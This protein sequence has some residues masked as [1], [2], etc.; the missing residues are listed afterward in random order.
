MVDISAYKR[1]KVSIDGTLLFADSARAYGLQ[2]RDVVVDGN[3]HRVNDNTSQKR[4]ND[5]GW[6]V[7][8]ESSGVWFGAYGSWYRD[9][10]NFCSHSQ[11]EL[12]P[13]Q[14]TEIKKS[15]D[16]AKIKADRL[17]EEAA[18]KAEATVENSEPVNSDHPYLLKK[19][20]HP[21]GTL[22][23]GDNILIPI[24]DIKNNIIS[25]QT[26]SP[27][28]EK[29]FL[30]KGQKKGGFH[31][32]GN[33]SPVL[34]LC[35]GF[36]TGAT[37]HEVT[38]ACVFVAFDRTNL[39]PVAAAIR[40]VYSNPIV[41]C[42]DNDQWTDGN[43][44]LTD[45]RIVSSSIVNSMVVYPSFKN[46][47]SKPTDFNDLNNLEGK[48]AVQLQLN[49][50][51]GKSLKLLYAD[52]IF[53]VTDTSDFVEDLLRDNEFS[54]IYGESNCGKT[55]FMMDLAIHV[56]LGIPWRG[57]EVEQGGVIYAALEGGHGTKNRIVAFREHYQIKNSIPLAV[58]PSNLNF[59]DTDGDI[60]ALAV[61]IAEAQ[62]RLGSVRLIVIDTLARAISGGDENS[63]MDMGKL[64]INAD[65]LRSVTG[66]HIA[67]I[68]HSGKDALKGARGHSSLRAAV[69][70]EIEISRLD[71]KSPSTI[72]IVKQREMEMIEEMS[73]ELKPV[74]LGTNSRGKQV[75]SCVVVPSE[76]ATKKRPEK[77]S[78]MQEFVYEA[79]VDCVMDYG[80]MRSVIKD[81]PQVK[82]VSYDDFKESLENRGYRDL[83]ATENK[84]TEQQVKS[85]TQTIRVNLKKR[86]KV[87]F[88]KNYIWLTNGE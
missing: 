54:V 88:N 34:Y 57:K 41:I 3:I 31:Q 51:P 52:D 10:V 22:K 29:R 82:C 43:P 21:H 84:T 28:G 73:F 63:S 27:N 30:S 18:Q 79:L 74:V 70:T 23:S 38:G 50:R 4:N 86:G 46:T 55:F 39:A 12:T 64:I 44:G 67:F 47:E 68:H 8:S 80:M 69:D 78:D 26:I 65:I 75:T 7:L 66:A 76:N 60:K 33:L 71:T 32:I 5:A 35:E 2:I 17:R 11:E 15:Q 6:Y 42:A 53:P 81:M 77:L 9:T 1:K 59:L 20:I 19:K 45:A 83:L 58:I 49:I 87:N 13:I 48:E 14:K 40:S 62:E 37:I 16:D 72:K 85:A 56:A 25:Y 61:A 24:Q 36:A